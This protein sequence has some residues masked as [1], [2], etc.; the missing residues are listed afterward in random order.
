LGDE[1]YFRIKPPRPAFWG[2]GLS[3]KK[4]ES[5]KIGK[6]MRQSVINLSLL[7]L[8]MFYCLASLVEAA[9]KGMPKPTAKD[10]CPVCGM[11]VTKYPDWTSAV[12]FKDGSQAFFDGAK[13]MFKYLLDLKRYNPSKKK[14]DIEA[15]WVLDYYSLSPIPAGKAWFVAGSDVFGP[16][17]RELIPLE[18]ESGA[19]EFLRDH[20][21]QKILKF[22]EVTPE[23][24]KPLD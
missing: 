10:K 21:G 14:D 5:A 13:D 18:K 6:K 23:V 9:E 20:K 22:S 19:K 11:F 4:T 7:S 15:I 8:L 3:I 2:R 17:G 24:I 1:L 12:V 16:M